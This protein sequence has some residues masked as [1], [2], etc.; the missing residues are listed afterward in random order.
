MPLPVSMWQKGGGGM[1]VLQTDILF[2]SKRS[3]NDQD[4]PSP[5]TSGENANT[6]WMSI[7]DISGAQKKKTFNPPGLASFTGFIQIRKVE[8]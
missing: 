8:L 1:T 5:S 3:S 2:K 4:G 7:P 6:C